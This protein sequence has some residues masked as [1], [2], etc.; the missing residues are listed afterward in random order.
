[1]SAQNQ[2]FLPTPILRRQDHWLPY[3]QAQMADAEILRQQ[4]KDPAPE[5]VGLGYS[6][7]PAANSARK[8]WRSPVEFTCEWLAERS[9]LPLA[10]PK[11][12]PNPARTLRNAYSRVY[13]SRR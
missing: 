2:H 8:R 1:M 11:R 10:K 9:G 12:D 4:G 3:S 6:A 5:L 13:G 7:F